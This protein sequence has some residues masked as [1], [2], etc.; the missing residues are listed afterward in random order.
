MRAHGAGVKA[1]RAIGKHAIGLVVN[2]EPKH[3]ASDSAADQAAVARPDAY[4]TPPPL[5]PALP[6]LHPPDMPALLA[7]SLPPS[8]ARGPRRPRRR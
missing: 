1:Y 5:H 7:A 8:P 2:L 4:Q 6:A 3:A